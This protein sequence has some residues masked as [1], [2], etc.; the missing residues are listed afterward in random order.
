MVE[1]STSAMKSDAHVIVT[2]DNTKA[3]STASEAP[4]DTA[5]TAVQP[6]VTV[7]TA[8]LPQTSDNAWQAMMLTASGMIGIVAALAVLNS[9]R[10]KAGS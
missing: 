7:A 9:R 10:V 6:T 2:T 4:I 5:A 1:A 3:T 8:T